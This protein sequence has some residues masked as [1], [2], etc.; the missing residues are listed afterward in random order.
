MATAGDIE[1]L[2]DETLRDVVD[3]EDWILTCALA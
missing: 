2:L 1:A 3:M